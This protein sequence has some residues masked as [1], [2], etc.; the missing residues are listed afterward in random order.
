MI[1]IK[2]CKD[3]KMSESF[4]WSK[5]QSVGNGK[6]V[7]FEDSAVQAVAEKERMVIE[8]EKQERIAYLKEEVKKAKDHA[9]GVAYLRN[10][11]MAYVLIILL[12][13]YAGSISSAFG[14]GEVA[15]AGGD[16]VIPF[17]TYGLATTSQFPGYMPKKKATSMDLIGAGMRKKYGVV[18]VYA[19]GVYV[20]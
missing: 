3:S 7:M 16:G 8:K 1:T 17:N 4:A 5:P 18:P 2:V 13:V 14:F 9:E 15:R 20:Y 10:V 19:I 11:F 6:A 12:S